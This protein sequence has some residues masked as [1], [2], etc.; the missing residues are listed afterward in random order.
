MMRMDYADLADISDWAYEA[1]CWMNMKG[2]VNG[3]PGKIL[4]PKGLATRAE[5]ATMLYRY[6]EVSGM[7]N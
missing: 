6:C 3:K 7:D 4:S 2:I 1:M 5:A